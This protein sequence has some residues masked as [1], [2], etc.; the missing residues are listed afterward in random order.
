MITF[1]TDRMYE[2]NDRMY[3]INDVAQGDLPTYYL[4]LRN[5]TVDIKM[6]IFVLLI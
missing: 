1:E 2:I 5:R 4:K 6:F 3:E